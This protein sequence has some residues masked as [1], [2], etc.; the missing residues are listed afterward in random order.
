MKKIT[1]KVYKEEIIKRFALAKNE[2]ASG[3]LAKPTPA[4]LRNLCSLKCVKGLK[5]ADEELMR[6][7]FETKPDENLKQSIERCNIDKFKP[8]ISFLKGEKDT[9]N[10]TRVGLAAILVDFEPRPYTL[11]MGN[12]RIGNEVE[13]KPHKD[14]DHI[15]QGFTL[16]DSSNKGLYRRWQ[17]LLFILLGIFCL[18]FV[19]KR[20]VYP[21]K[22]C[23]QWQNDHYEK[24][25]CQSEINNLYA[26][27][28]IVPFEKNTATLRKLTVC[29]TTTFY[30]GEK[31]IIWYCKVN[32]VPEYFDGP[33]FHPVTEKGLR[34]V[35]DYI[36]SK[37]VRS[38]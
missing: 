14:E 7:F 15:I 3:I 18:G 16:E 6:V 2:D 8:I 31:A 12:E 26:A 29:D 21:E 9:E 36:I 4:L 30:E 5:P 38:K 28:P 33:G 32:G 11:F 37:Y 27:S 34:P 35:T 19:V 13:S 20:I 10:P 1:F 23:M 24:I 22:Q 17:Y 25:D